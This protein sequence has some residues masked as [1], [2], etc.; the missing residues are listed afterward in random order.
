ME[1]MTVDAGVHDRRFLAVG[2]AHDWRPLDHPQEGVPVTGLTH[3]KAQKVKTR[4]CGASMS[5]TKMLC[6]WR[7]EFGA[8]DSV[9]VPEMGLSMKGAAGRR[10]GRWRPLHRCPVGSLLACRVHRP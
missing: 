10:S 9:R 2:I 5:A 4:G 1:S 3:G 8:R 6:R 7:V